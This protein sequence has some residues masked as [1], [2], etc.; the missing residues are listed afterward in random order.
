MLLDIIISAVVI[1][2]I[3]MGH[4]R[5]F[6]RSLCSTFSFVL[7]VVIAFLT[8]GK[9]TELV[10]A[11]PVGEFIADKISAGLGNVTIDFS[12]VPEVLRS[13]FREGVADATEVMAHNL[14]VVIIGIISVVVTIIAVR[15]ILKILFRILDIFAKLPVIKQCNKLLGIVLGILNGCLWACIIVFA[16]TQISLLPDAGFVDTLADGSVLVPFISG[17]NLFGM[18]LS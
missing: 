14:T 5:G 18:F 8:Y 1:L 17:I 2:C 10:A 3:F 9:I 4:K 16:V 7:S 11:S 13:S 12:S 15:L 6:V